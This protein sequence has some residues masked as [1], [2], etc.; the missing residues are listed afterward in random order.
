[1][2]IPKNTEINF[3]P[4]NYNICNWE[5]IC[6]LVLEKIGIFSKKKI[7]KFDHRLLESIAHGV[8]G[9]GEACDL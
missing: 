2:E 3:I 8:G 4:Q 9:W 5:K 7:Y 1:M 6:Q